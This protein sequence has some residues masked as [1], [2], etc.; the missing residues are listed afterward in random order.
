MRIS[1]LI[2]N[3]ETYFVQAGQSVL[4]AARWMVE[5]NVGALPVLDGGRLVG[6]FSERDIMK[7]VVAEERDPARTRVA[8]VMTAEPLV[9]APDDDV[10]HCMVLMKQHGFRHL[11]ICGEDRKLAGLV[12]LR[13]ML[14]HEVSEKDGEVQM[15]RAYIGAGPME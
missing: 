11:P 7:R 10:Q 2:K 12:S 9:V 1:E 4:E 6:I 13:D 3:R 14:L 8:D 15:M 5:R